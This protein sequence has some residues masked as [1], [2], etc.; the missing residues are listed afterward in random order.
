MAR[1]PLTAAPA[2]TLALALSM[3]ACVGI[4]RDEPTDVT[5][6]TER[7]VPACPAVAA[8]V[9]PDASDAGLFAME[10]ELDPATVTG[11][12]RR[13]T[14]RT[15]LTPVEVHK[16]YLAT[17]SLRVLEDEG[18]EAEVLATDGSRRIALKAQACSGGSAV[19][20]TTAAEQPQQGER[21]EQRS[22]T[23][24]QQG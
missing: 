18:Y 24:A 2:L 13:Y 17:T 12:T 21:D 10:V 15:T 23:T 4:Q 22:T 5:E 8:P 3:G 9:A 20:A 19:D 11:R 14:G 6:A 16:A 7:A 1:A